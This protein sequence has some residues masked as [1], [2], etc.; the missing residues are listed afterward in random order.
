MTPEEA[1]ELIDKMQEWELK[2]PILA[3]FRR[4]YYRIESWFI[5]SGVDEW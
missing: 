5:K 4:R 3:W 2:H 1:A